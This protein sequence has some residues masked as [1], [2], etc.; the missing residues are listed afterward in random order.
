M[1]R[2]IQMPRESNVLIR[3][4]YMVLLVSFLYLTNWLLFCYCIPK[5]RC[6]GFITKLFCS[7]SDFQ[8]HFGPKCLLTQGKSRILY[9]LRLEV[10]SLL[11]VCSSTHFFLPSYRNT[12][13]CSWSAMMNFS[14]SR[15]AG[16]KG[17]SRGVFCFGYLGVLRRALA[18]DARG[19]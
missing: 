3:F 12:D 16:V 8:C 9:V 4:K 15:G 14:V 1:F 11:S 17:P 19:G 7:S 13:Q 6:K 2:A 5:A 18:V 10:S